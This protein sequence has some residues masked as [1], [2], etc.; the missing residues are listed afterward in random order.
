MQVLLSLPVSHLSHLPRPPTLANS[1]WPR[2]QF[3]QQT[4]PRWIGQIPLPLPLPLSRFLFRLCE[5]VRLENRSCLLGLVHPKSSVVRSICSIPQPCVND[6]TTATPSGAYGKADFLVSYFIHPFLTCGMR[7]HTPTCPVLQGIQH[8]G[9][10]HDPTVNHNTTTTPQH[11]NPHDTSSSS[12]GRSD[13]C[14]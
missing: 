4:D 8:R 10:P 14:T 12:S 11:L 2:S 5:W 13:I 6:P 9:A 1:A 3:L 7:N